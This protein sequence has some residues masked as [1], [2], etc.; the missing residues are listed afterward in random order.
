MLKLKLKVLFLWI[1]A[2]IVPALANADTLV[3]CE[4]KNLIGQE[5]SISYLI[6]AKTISI[7][8][9]GSPDWRVVFDGS[10]A[11]GRS[12]GVVC[13]HSAFDNF[14]D[15]S[16]PNKNAYNSIACSG[17]TGGVVNGQLRARFF[18]DGEGIFWCSIRG[19]KFYDYKLNNCSYQEQP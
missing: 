2:S 16:A 18:G 17:T 15:G 7:Q 6:D 1:L 5:A 10:T 11:C 12:N 8:V 4:A 19:T 9:E 3:L 13:E 14:S